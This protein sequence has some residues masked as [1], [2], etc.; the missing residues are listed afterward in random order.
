M[1]RIRE[2]IHC[3]LIAIILLFSQ[4]NSKVKKEDA[5]LTLLRIE[6]SEFEPLSEFEKMD[7]L[8][9]QLAKLANRG[10]TPQSRRAL[11]SKYPNWSEIPTTEIL[12]ILKKEPIHVTC[13]RVSYI[14]RDIYR[15]F[16]WES[17]T[18]NFGFVGTKFTHEVTL[19]AE[20]SGK[21]IIL[22]D[23][24]FNA[25]LQDSLHQHIDFLSF[26]SD[27][28][29]SIPSLEETVFNVKIDTVS[30]FVDSGIL[31]LS[32][33]NCIP[34][35]VLDLKSDLKGII[36]YNYIVNQNLLLYDSCHG[37]ITELNKSMDTS[38]RYEQL[39]LNRISEMEDQIEWQKRY[40]HLVN[41]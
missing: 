4:C 13:G 21:K 26:I 11:E 24:Y 29:D 10:H 12:L 32:Q 37:F 20:G 6:R 28:K 8:R 2:I 34:S 19:V 33:I 23:A 27:L 36:T 18:F 1:M 9:M 41:P 15:I 14:L 25:T 31:D 40:D 35:F 30:L 7:M 5:I 22:E 39:F 17:T 16:G 3:L 38:V